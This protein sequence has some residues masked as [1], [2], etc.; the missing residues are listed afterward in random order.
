MNDDGRSPI[1]MGPVVDVVAG[2][3][4]DARGRILLARRT[5]GRDLAGLWEFPGGKREPGE[6][7][8]AAL[9]RELHEELGI[10]I[11]V[12]APLIAVPQQYPHKRLRLDVRRIASWRGTP[13][14]LDGQALAWVP[15]HKLPSYAMPPADRPVVAA[16]LQPDRYL[17]TPE[18]GDDDAAW[19]AALERALG[20][21]IRRVQL[22]ASSAIE[23][24]RWQALVGNAVTRCREASAE[25]FVNHDAALAQQT[26]IGLHLRAE[27]LAAF[28]PATW[29]KELPL[30]A[31]CHDAGELR[32]AERI[33]CTFAV[34]GSLRA[35]PTHSGIAG[36]G[37]SGF[38]DLR[39]GVSLPLYAIGG[40]GADDMAQARSHG[41]QGIAAIRSLWPR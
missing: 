7:S 34:L 19:L 37:W 18:P 27:Q 39:E 36:I 14:G 21:G 10:A 20:N 26:G 31:S 3:I 41:A 6:S 29:P 16:L 33:G 40:L 38:S 22:R 5:E 9:A 30:A 8:E 4:T 17:V 15:P 25:V 13:K 32:H 35:T 24:R 28:E 23:Q 12:G 1:V 11:D 2:V